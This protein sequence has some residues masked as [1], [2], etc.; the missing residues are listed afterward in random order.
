MSKESPALSCRDN[1]PSPSNAPPGLLEFDMLLW[2]EPD[3]KYHAGV[4]PW[5]AGYEPCEAFSPIHLLAESLRASSLLPGYAEGCRVHLN[6][7]IEG[8]G[9]EGFDIHLQHFE[10]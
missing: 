10:A 6:K 1:F 5:T 3:T 7:E 4:S 2:D 9:V 8:K